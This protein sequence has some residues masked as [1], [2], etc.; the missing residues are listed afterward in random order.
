MLEHPHPQHS[1]DHGN[2]KVALR[3]ELGFV[4]N[5]AVILN[6]V[7]GSGIFITP[8]D[9][10][11]HTKSFGLSLSLWAVGGV[12]S[13][14]AALCYLELAL[15][16]KKS[17]STYIFI[18]EAYSFGRRKPWMEGL[19]SFCGFMVAWTNMIIL[20]PL[21]NAVILL[22]LGRYMCRPFFI[23]CNEVPIYA[24]KMIALFI[25]SQLTVKTSS[26]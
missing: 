15:L 5:S 7:L 1:A 8:S 26:Q 14:L 24:V 17:G 4:G 19:S 2:K 20:Q 3:K 25:S 22:A 11:R 13:L 23:S 6:L 16:I 9:I 18:K 21:A 10:L 12:M